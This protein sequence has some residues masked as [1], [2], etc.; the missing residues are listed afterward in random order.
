MDFMLKKLR[1]PR[2][3]K[4]GEFIKT[5]IAVPGASDENGPAF[6]IPAAL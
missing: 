2:S 3:Q 4:Q 1:A 5:R 6:L